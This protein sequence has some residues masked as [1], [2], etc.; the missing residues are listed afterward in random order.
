M[1]YKTRTAYNQYTKEFAAKF[2][3]YAET[4]ISIEWAGLFLKSLQGPHLLDLGCGPGIHASYFMQ[5][6]LKVYA[7][8]FS[9]NMLS[10]CKEQSLNAVMMDIEHIAFKKNSFD[11]VWAH[12]SLLHIR[13]SRLDSVINALS[14]I[15]K[16]SG[17]LYLSLKEGNG[18]GY[19]ADV[20]YPGVER[21]WA[22][23]TDEEVNIFLSKYFKRLYFSKTTNGRKI[24]L[25]YIFTLARQGV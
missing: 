11:G 23:Y 5:N 24:L 18:E 19:K 16:P 2:K 3:T 22:Y 15:L 6:G 4:E 13:K 9:E 21:Y 1:D 25:N 7:V 8:D 14:M 20:R 10:L 12:T 17:L